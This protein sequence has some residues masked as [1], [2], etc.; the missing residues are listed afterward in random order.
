MQSKLFKSINYYYILPF[1]D[2]AGLIN[3]SNRRKATEKGHKKYI[4]ATQIRRLVLGIR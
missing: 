1:V 3:N 2:I 4:T